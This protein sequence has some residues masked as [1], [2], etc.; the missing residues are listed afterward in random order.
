MPRGGTLDSDASN[1]LVFSRV[2]KRNYR[3][4]FP[5]RDLSLRT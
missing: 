5:G 4:G 2:Q 1:N 3:L